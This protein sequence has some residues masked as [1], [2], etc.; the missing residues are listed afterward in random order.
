MNERLTDDPSA[1]GETID[2]GAEAESGPPGDGIV[3]ASQ[4]YPTSLAILPLATRPLFPKMVMPL[5]LD[6]PALVAAIEHATS[7]GGMVGLVLRKSAGRDQDEEE[8]VEPPDGEPSPVSRPPPSLS[9]PDPDLHAVGVIAQVLKVQ[10]PNEGPPTA[11]LG[12][13]DRLELLRVLARKPFMTAEVKYLYEPR[14]PL[15]DELKAYSLA[16]INSIKDLIAQSPLFKE[17]LNLLV[18]Q[19]NFE[20]PA[21]LADYAAFLTS[22][23]PAKLQQ[24]LETLDVRKR[25][26]LVLDL[27]RRELD[28]AKLQSK[29]RQDLEKRVSEQQ[30]EFLLR[31][32]L[33][34]IKKE[35]GLEKD[36]K[37]SQ[38]Q[39]FMDRL[40]TRTPSQE[41]LDRIEEEIE[42]LKLLEPSSPEFN[43]TRNYLEWLTVLPWGVVSKSD[44]SLKSARRELDEHHYGLDDVKERILEFIAAGLM[45]GGNFG[46]SIICLV[47]PPGVGK[48]SIGR[49]VAKALG[50]EFYRFSVGGMSDEAEIKGHRRTYIGAMPGKFLQALRVCKTADPVIMLDEIDK[51]GTSFRGD[52][53]SALL[54][55]LDPEQNKDFLDHYLDVRF[56]LSSV[57][58]V[59]T[60]NQLDTIPAP[61]LDRMEVINLSGYI[62]EEKL[63]IGQR[64]IVPRELK[65]LRIKP[66]QLSIGR[67]ALREIIDGYS[68]DAGVRSLEQNI[69]KIVRKSAV[70]LLEQK[71]DSIRIGAEEVVQI[72]GKRIFTHDEAYEQPLPGVVLGLAWTNMGGDTLL[73]EATRVKSSSPGFKQTGQLGKVMIESSEIAYTLVRSLCA[74]R[75][76]CAGFFDESFIHLHVPA[77]ATPK[78]G[79]SAG[80]TIAA[81]LYTLAHNRAILPA[82]AMTGELDLSGRVLP[83]GGIKEKVIAAKRAGVKQL[84]LPRANEGDFERLP[85]HIKRGSTAHFV[86]R[87]EQIVALCLSGRNAGSSPKPA[88]IAARASSS[89]RVARSA[90]SRKSR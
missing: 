16:V 40:K 69:K 14:T 33:H 54:E 3:V 43:V 29:L 53:A 24:V 45:K 34:A 51:V 7:H 49:S 66:G 47:G 37:E 22:A 75:A 13:H 74:E 27:L 25:L 59:C 77:G 12:A 26:E 79:P 5:A 80:V 6:T 31:Q 28:I 72:L 2:A 15:T 41:A 21:R 87:F 44:V 19:G 81:A 57:L 23:R 71:P 1:T 64:F 68:R 76:D 32:Q 39:R 78:D 35:L 18:S 10:K 38:I 60:A 55:A 50:R 9:G 56:D 83:V 84:V 63:E 4:V 65:E 70:R 8:S 46:G 20:E 30:R 90:N 61:L 67:A 36:D 82:F 85:E 17:E 73:V 52:P 89:A 88:K 48:T 42:K 62:L 86:D 58:F 11:L